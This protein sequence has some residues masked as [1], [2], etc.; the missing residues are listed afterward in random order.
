MRILLPLILSLALLFT[1]TAQ[2]TFTSVGSGNF[3]TTGAGVWSPSPIASDFTNG[4]N[5]FIIAD[6]DAIII[7]DATAISA[8]SIQVGQGGAASTLTFGDGDADIGSLST[9]TFTVQ[10]NGTVNVN[11]AAVAHTLA[12]TGDYAGEGTLTLVNGSGTVNTTFNNTSTVVIAGSGTN[13]FNDL[14]I[15]GGGNVI[16]VAA[17]TVSGNFSIGPTQSN[18]TFNSNN[19]G[20]TFLGNFTLANSA[21]FSTSGSTTDFNGTSAQTLDFSGGTVEFND[22]DFD[23]GGTKTING[24]LFTNGGTVEVFAGTIIADQSAGNTHTIYNLEVNDQN[25]L[26]L[27]GSTINWMG[28]ELRF[29]AGEGTDGT[30]DLGVGAGGATD[31]SNDVDIVVVDGNLQLERSDLLIVDGDITIQDPAQLIIQGSDGTV[32]DATITDHDGTHTLTM[33][34][35]ADIYPQGTDNFPTSFNSYSFGTNSFVRYQQAYNQTISGEDDSGTLIPYANLLLNQGGNKT[36]RNT[37]N[38][39]VDV[40]IYL[41]GGSVFVSSHAA[42]ITVGDDIVTDGD[43]GE[44]FL[45]T[46]S[47]LNLNGT[48]NQTLQDLALNYGIRKLIITNPDNEA[49]TVNIDDNIFLLAA[50]ND[51]TFAGQSLF[52]IENDG[53]NESNTLVVDVDA[54]AIIGQADGFD[55]YLD[56]VD[57]G[58]N[59]EIFTSGTNFLQNFDDTNDV[60]TFDV[61]SIIRFD[62]PS[63]QNIPSISGSFGSIEFN[64][65]GD[66]YIPAGSTSLTILGD[67]TRAGGNFTFFLDQSA[68]STTIS[69]YIINVSGNWSLGTAYTGVNQNN[70]TSDNTV[71]FVGTDQIISASN[72][73]NISFGGSGTKTIQGVLNLNGDFGITAS[74]VTVTTS[75]NIN[76][77]GDIASSGGNWSE[78][79]GTVFQQ[80]G[81]T[82]TFSTGGTPTIT[83]QATSYF[84]DLDVTNN[85]TLR[86]A[87]ATD[88]F[89]R[90]N[91]DFLLQTGSTLDMDG[92]SNT[93]HQ[94]LR[95]G[96]DIVIDGPAATVE[97][98]NASSSSIIMDGSIAQNFD[99]EVSANY[100]TLE[101]QGVGEKDLIDQTFN[102]SGDF[103]VATG[104]TV[105]GNGETINFRGDNWTVNG[106]FVHANIVNFLKDNAGGS[107]I[108]SA[109][110]F[111]NFVVGDGVTATTVDLNGNIALE[112]N[113]TIND[114]S[115]LDANS[116]NIQLEADWNG[117]GTFTPGTGTVTIIGNFSQI[118]TDDDTGSALDDE[119]Q[120]TAKAFYNLRVNNADGQEV[121]VEDDEVQDGILTILN[122]FT[123][124][125]GTFRLFEDN[126]GNITFGSR[127]RIGGDLNLSGGTLLYQNASTPTFVNTIELFANGTGGETHSINLGGNIV[128]N[129]EITNDE[130]D[131]YQLTNTFETQDD[132]DDNFTLN[133]NSST[134]DLNGQIM[135]INRGGFVMQDGTLDIDAGSSL[136]LDGQDLGSVTSFDKTGGQLNLVGTSETP[137]VLTA[138]TTAGF[139]FEQSGGDFTANNYTIAQTASNGINLTGGTL[140]NFSDGTFTNGVGTAYL[141]IQ[142]PVAIGTIVATGVTFNAGPT[143]NVNT[144]INNDGTN[145]PAS[146]TIEFVIAGGTLSGE[147]SENDDPDGG[148]ADGYVLW[149]NDPGFT[150]SATAAN[151]NW[152]DM[153][154]WIVTGGDANG[155]GYPDQAA[156]IVYIQTSTNAPNIDASEDW[157]IGRLTLNSGSLTINTG[158]LNVDGNVTVFS[159]AS[160]TLT[161]ATDSLKVAG[162]FANDGTFT[163]TGGNGIITFD[164]ADG[165]HSINSGSNFAQLSINGGTDATYSLGSSLT[166]T[167]D[168]SLTGGTFD[169]SSGF[170]FNIQGDWTVSGGT[171]NPG[172]GTVDFNGSGTQNISGG[173]IYNA[174]FNGPDI[175]I[176]GNISVGGELQIISGNVEL[177]GDVTVFVGQDWNNDVGV[178]GF[179]AGTGTVVFNGEGTQRIDAVPSAGSTTFNNV[180]FQGSGAR[181]VNNSITI[182][183]DLTISSSTVNLT[184]GNTITGGGGTLF[185]SG[186]IL[187]IED[188][189]NFP[190]GFT[191]YNLV[192]GQVR[193]IFIDNDQTVRGGITY[194]NLA[195]LSNNNDN[196]VLLRTLD[197]DVTVNGVLSFGNANVSYDDFTLEVGTH[198]LTITGDNATGTAHITMSADDQITFTTGSFVHSGSNEWDIDT[199]LSGTTF[200]DVTLTGGRKDLLGSLTI[201]GNFSIGDGVNFDQNTNDITNDAGDTFTLG[202]NATYENN[203]NNSLP[204]NFATYS[205]A[206][207]SSVTLNNT[208]AA[209]SIISATYGHLFLNSNFN[210][211]LAGNITV[212]GDF[213]MNADGTL[214]DNNFNLTLNGDFIDIQDYTPSAASTITFSGADQN[215]VDN[216]GA[217][218]NLTFS[219]VVFGGTGTKTLNPNGA[220]EVEVLNTMTVNSGVTI[221]TGDL[222]RFRGNSITN[223][224][225][226]IT[227]D[228][229]DPFTFDGVDAP[230]VVSLNPG[231]NSLASLELT[232]SSSVTLNTTGLDIE[233]G[234]ITIG[235]GSTLN[236]GDNITSN[237]ASDDIILN[238]TGVLAFGA[239]GAES[240]IIFDRATGGQQRIPN[241]DATNN[242]TRITNIPNVTFSGTGQKLMEGSLQVNDIVLESTITELDVSAS[243]YAIEVRGNWDNQ[244]TSF[245]EQEGTVTFYSNNSTANDARTIT[246]NDDQFAV[247]TIDG[248]TT[249]GFIRTYTLNG[250]LTVEGQGS[251]RTATEIALTLTRGTLDLNGNELQLGNNDGGD[252]IPETSTIGANGSLI[253]DEGATL[254]FSTDDDDGDNSNNLV[255]SAILQV[256]GNLTLDGSPGNTATFTRA[257]GVDRI[258]LSIESGGTIDADNYS[259]NFLTDAG[260]QIR[261]GADLVR[262]DGVGTNSTFSNGSFSNMST[263]ANTIRR[264]INIEADLSDGGGTTDINI[265]NITFNYDGTPA[266]SATDSTTNIRVVAAVAT[267]INFTNT[268][269]TIGANGTLYENDVPNFVNW[270]AVT[271]TTW[272]AGAGTSDWFDAANWGGVLP[273][274]TVG[275]IIPL[276][277]PF[278][279]LDLDTRTTVQVADITITDGIL[280]VTDA[281]TVTV[282]TDQLSVLGDFIVEDG[283]TVIL[284]TSLETNPFE[285]AGSFEIADN[286]S[287]DNGSIIIELNGATASSP[288]FSTGSS[289]SVGGLLISGDADYQF[290]GTEI[291]IDGN[292]TVTGA[293]SINPLDNDYELRISGDV[294]FLNT[295]SFNTS[296]DGETI[297]DGAG[298]TVVE[299]V[300]DALTISGSGVKSLS[301]VTTN[302]IFTI[303]NGATALGTGAITWGDDVIINSGGAFQGASSI[304]YTLNGDDWIGG[305]NSYTN[306]LGT[307]I[308]NYSGANAYIRQISNTTTDSVEF[309]NVILRGSANMNLGRFI[310]SNQ[311]DGNVR[312]SGDLTI[313]NTIGELRVNDYLIS[314]NVT[315]TGTMTLQAGERI[316][317]DGADN[318]PK[319]FG[320]YAIDATSTVAY[321]APFAQIVRGGFA[322]GNLILNNGSVSSLNADTDVNGDLT[323]TAADTLDVT[324][325]NYNLRIGGRWD[326]EAGTTDG[327]FLARNGTVIFDGTTDQIIQLGNTGTQDFNILQLDKTSGF[328]DLQN[329]DMTVGDDLVIEDGELD[330]NSLEVSI[331]GNLDITG[332]GV[333][334]SNAAGDLLFNATTGS[335]TIRTNGSNYL[336][337]M[338]INATGITYTM[339][340][341][342]IVDNVLT[343]TAGT[344]EVDGN[345][346]EVGNTEDV[347]NV[348]GTLNVSTTANPGGTLA[349]GDQVQLVIQPGGAINIVGT[350][351]QVATVTRRGSTGTYGFTVTGNGTPGTIGARFYTM[352]FMD[353]NGIY[354][355]GNGSVDVTNNFSDG[356]FTNGPAGGTYLR[357]ENTQDFLDA[358]GEAIQNVVFNNDPGGGAVN[359]TKTVGTSGTI[360]LDN[361]TGEFSGESFDSDPNN[362][363]TWLI[364]PALTWT[365]TVNTDWF[366]TGNW[367]DELGNP[368][369]NPPGT[370]TTTDYTTID[371]II[372]SAPA[373]ATLNPPVIG[374]S[375]TVIEIGGNLTID[376]NTLSINTSDADVDADL[377][378]TG[379][380]TMDDAIFRSIGSDDDIE[381]G[382]SFTLNGSSTLL[383]GT[384]S[385]FT[386]NSASG[387]V[388]L[389]ASSSFNDLTIDVIGTLTLSNNLTVNGDLNLTSTIGIFDFNGFDVTVGGN[390]I[391]ASASATSI[392]AGTNSLTLNSTTTPITFTPGSPELY[393]VTLGDGLSTVTYNLG[394]NLDL[395]NALNITANTTLDL[396]GFDLGVGDSNADVETFTLDGNLTVDG[397]ETV[398]LGTNTDLQVNGN[399]QLSGASDAN[400]A[401]L[402][403]KGSSGNYTVNVNNGGEFGADFY[404]ISYTGGDGIDFALGSTLTFV[405]RAS[406]GVDVDGD[407]NDDNV[408]FRNGS[409]SNGAGNAYLTLANS[410]GFVMDSLKA[411]N[412][413]FSSGPT[414]NV[415][416]TGA[417]DDIVFVDPAGSLQG[418]TFEDDD[419]SATSGNIRWFYTNPLFTWVGDTD[420]DYNTASNWF[421][422]SQGAEALAA[423]TNAN[424]VNI[425]TVTMPNVYP[426]I[427][428][429]G[430]SVSDLTIA[431][432]A[433][434]T[435]DAANTFTVEGDLVNS[436]TFT[437]NGDL[438][439][440]GTLTNTGTISAGP[441][442]TVTQIL[443]EN[444]LFEGGTSFNNLTFDAN[445]SNF[446]A[447]T[448]ASLD[449]NGNL[450]ITDNATLV[451]ADNSHVL[452]VGGNFTV[453]ETNNGVFTMTDGSVAFDGSGTQTI[454]NTAGSAITFNA[455]TLS[456]GSSK[457][458]SG[459]VTVNGELILNDNSTSLSLGATTLTLNSDLTINDGAAISSGTSTIVLSGSSVQRISGSGASTSVT[460]NNLTVN[461]TT[462]GNSDIQL[463]VDAIVGGIL[464]FQQGVIESTSSNQ[465]VFNDN[466]TV[467]YDGVAETAPSGIATDGNSYAVG[468]VLKIGD[469]DFVFPIGDGARFARMGISSINTSSATDQYSAEYF[470]A[471]Q[472]NVADPKNGA[473]VRVSGLEYW[474]L[475]NEN[476]HSGEPLVTLFWDAASEV[477]EPASLLVAHYNGASWDDEGNGGTTGVAAGGTITS[478]NNL[479]SFSPITLASSSAAENPLPVTL[480]NFSGIALNNN[481]E[482][483]WTTATELNND[484]FEIQHSLDGIQFS[485]IGTVEGNGDSNEL[486]N[487]NYT[488]ANPALGDNFYRLRQVDF[489]GEDET[490]ETIQVYNDFYYDGMDVTV[491]PNPAKGEDVNIR[492]ISGD[493]HTPFGLVIVDLD[494]KVIFEKTM[495]ASTNLDQKLI[496]DITLKSG[497]YIATFKQG[498]MVVSKRLIIK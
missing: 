475:T 215:I 166:V 303:N 497:V 227:T 330:I 36:L 424:T 46:S 88:D 165:S 226:I 331:G 314:N 423:P 496:K 293:A 26:D 251:L 250:N 60:S 270:P 317:V 232:N 242:P 262:K 184:A 255:E 390:F 162:S 450:N 420:S 91:D 175:D 168:F 133:A 3:A 461:N 275:A 130:G 134:L 238:T 498:D 72:F 191:D 379:A 261:S 30:I 278:P 397:G 431:S 374:N 99:N 228:A 117:Y 86:L 180:T 116:F 339:L 329:N 310:N 105:N 246:T 372:P 137:A 106:N 50:A 200:N 294:T 346:L 481:V 161:Q 172:V 125:S 327:N 27:T 69:N 288:I 35:T 57:V 138:L 107:T 169:G 114:L 407:T 417:L 468:P 203:S 193:Y 224:G 451:I 16:N 365:G 21:G 350:S 131:T 141:T 276:V 488:H 454:S 111:N 56:A 429:D 484:F 10:S 399:F 75:T 247:L 415:S 283:G 33:T 296:V 391:N 158:E 61:N 53:G 467:S 12:I 34:A 92:A 85:T 220:D 315:G 342:M 425:P 313:E 2:T 351:G 77:T 6:G 349:L 54:N 268:A 63:D 148:A 229:G 287:F 311:E 218:D 442:S 434:L 444:I 90:A 13:T 173:T 284:E 428:T 388:T 214:V 243:N 473:I 103:I 20:I 458:F 320:T 14:T 332:T 186:G 382:G 49:R 354:V 217:A 55:I 405:P 474:D 440:Q 127:T 408:G 156:D 432:G 208:S 295:T 82:T 211:N 101:F 121:R 286:A 326:T 47:T 357:I 119:A 430:L 406:S 426:V 11:T 322:Y 64:G 371:V 41:Y 281:G 219:N 489:D 206:A 233:N 216:D 392:N 345:T 194:N 195:M 356:T 196:A 486:L 398:S 368:I 493:S 207:T 290:N 316:E 231:T 340:D 237:I 302:D 199:D 400:R 463:G 257:S 285:V 409:F 459:D 279:I 160:L 78:A 389:E 58:Q 347:I 152:D 267:N 263:T 477:T 249:G 84:D 222:F 135:V 436:G 462:V 480:V 198:T 153:N 364:P 274:N 223:N 71:N 453:D 94:D 62:S 104:T 343:I 66:K 321:E 147:A 334:T 469:D 28:G 367:E 18:I 412:V 155:N 190:N 490:L 352:E 272:T 109:S 129:F 319:D 306:Q 308:F 95:V 70:P 142:N 414:S 235:D 446:S 151:S 149:T 187:D 348:F 22:V 192:G 136:V 202:D 289:N 25:A 140:T 80:D 361:Y 45:A 457:I 291:D 455:L 7:H 132:A 495:E 256:S 318:F 146:G 213:D 269:G 9:G 466:A 438:I 163:Q 378:I 323:I 252:P 150:W 19:T 292:V 464:D 297:L 123:V 312:M 124:E 159:G 31:A 17:F 167:N 65:N 465:V 273:S 254:S 483:S 126:T 81:G 42:D 358:S 394:S 32:A 377:R 445:G 185:M 40:D 1:S 176:I 419:A 360:E 341:N 441:S 59:C 304:E 300:A 439:V 309:H 338:T 393:N 110:N 157:N 112:A 98:S 395:S 353:S 404:N 305:Q 182:S 139:T 244:G 79:A 482:L 479:S 363:I 188:T 401:N 266:N 87:G 416:R 380:V 448:T 197:G 476:G 260:I 384:G 154:N 93:D 336:G 189:D 5:T 298:Q 435:L 385:L 472:A 248:T 38:L 15:D 355:D 177:V 183:G 383:P 471:S 96:G 418:A 234:D 24:N 178:A 271:T 373:Q 376:G 52:Q 143:F 381:I 328:V 413:S 230:G 485:P 403:R 204:T 396:S 422:E 245:D 325:N 375:A 39:S 128:R 115:E 487:Y 324:T 369:T 164:G 258:G 201:N 265:D 212:E 8:A 470:F 491:Y 344:L 145:V 100:P 23:G 210:M 307:V 447:T 97:F 359:I 170:T 205:I 456:G 411:D 280:R 333:L 225:S 113:L 108:V 120:L 68:P 460:F 370:N 76:L 122:D 144:N 410:F 427:S 236:F 240:T 282:G 449:V 366:E 37:D 209:Q 174:D 433:E 179:T 221:T 362:L 239:E 478:A 73:H 29:G 171:Y 264:Y 241:I 494:G 277:I 43:G 259:F 443:T 74:G 102:I 335:P 301:A 492:I 48:E 386:Y 181:N 89:I 337:N 83:T 437:I 299:L 387:P 51:L 421:D 4:L 44:R 452:S 118:R 67:I 402:T 253:V